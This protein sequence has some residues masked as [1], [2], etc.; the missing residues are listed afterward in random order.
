MARYDTMTARSNVVQYESNISTNCSN[1]D[2]VALV[3]FHFFF[4]CQ[5]VDKNEKKNFFS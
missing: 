2:L 5:Y 4:F 3:V 1:I